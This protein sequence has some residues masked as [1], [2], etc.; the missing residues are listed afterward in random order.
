AWQLAVSLSAFRHYGWLLSSIAAAIVLATRGIRTWARRREAD[1]P[2]SRALVVHA[3]LALAGLFAAMTLGFDLAMILLGSAAIVPALI[4]GRREHV[5]LAVWLGAFVVMTPL[6]H[7]YTRLLLPAMPAAICLTLW[8]LDAGWGLVEGAAPGPSRPRQDS[9]TASFADSVALGRAARIAASS[10]VLAGLAVFSASHPFGLIPSASLWRRWST[11]ESYRSFGIAIERSTPSDAF[12]L[13]Q[14]LPPMPL[15]C[16]YP[17]RWLMLD[18]LPFTELLPR[19][20]V[21]RPCYLAVDD[22]GAHGEGHRE[23]LKTLLEKRACLEKVASVPND[24]NIVALLDNLSPWEVAA[25]LS[26]AT[27]ANAAR[28]GGEKTDFLP[29]ALREMGEDVIV[30]YRVDR[31]CVDS[32]AA[33]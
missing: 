9:P 10:A 32:Q 6:Y 25:K 24:L 21:G 2:R 16:Y 7:P 13:C 28:Q 15:Y 4:F 1:A 8:L 12:V 30:L 5:L 33:Q 11:H 29:P 19:V 26:G 18:W 20:P 31:A 14:G 27:A 22:W 23:A 17:R 3:T